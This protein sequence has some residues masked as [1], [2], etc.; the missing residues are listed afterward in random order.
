MNAMP[1][2]SF[3]STASAKKTD[4]RVEQS[5]RAHRYDSPEQEKLA[6]YVLEKHR[7]ALRELAK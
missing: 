4:S 1:K 6:R 5:K 3:F 2:H 7:E